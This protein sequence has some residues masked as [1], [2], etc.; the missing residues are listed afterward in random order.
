MDAKKSLVSDNG[1]PSDMAEDGKF[2]VSGAPTAVVGVGVG[3][4]SAQS[5]ERMFAAVRPDLNAAFVVAVRQD[6]GLQIQ[7]VVEILTRATQA[8]VQ[9]AVDGDPLTPNRIH[10]GGCDDMITV[11]HGEVRVRPASEPVGHRG[12]ID[13][14]LISLAEHAQEQAVAVILTGLGSDGAAGVT[15]TKKFGGLSIVEADV[16]PETGAGVSG[17]AAVA[18]L[19]L[20]VEE[21]GQQIALY[22]ANLADVEAIGF[23]EEGPDDLEAQVGQIT[24][25]LRNVTSHD[26]HGY[27]RGTFVRRVHR[28][29]QVLQIDSISDYIATLRADTQEVQNLFQD[30]LIGVTQFFRDPAEF[31]ALERELPRLFA[32]KGPED[33]FRVWVLGCATGEEAYSLAI[34]LREHLSTLNR[35]PEVQI[36]ATDLD[37]RSLGLARAGRYSASIADH[38]RPDR[39]ERWFVREGDTYCVAKELR[40]MCVFSPHNIVKDAPFSRLDILSCRNLLIY[41]SIELQNRVIPI[42]HFA[43]KSGGVLF[44]GASENVT[45]HGKLFAPV[46]RKNRLFRRLETA[47]RVVPDFPLTPRVRGS[48]PLDLGP[49][50]VLARVTAS[51]GRQAEAIVE[52]Y[53]PA[54]VIVD[55][56]G[57]VVHFSGHTGRYIE[58]SAGAPTMSLQ[59]LVHRDL[60][61]DIRAALSRAAA[62]GGRVEMPR[63]LLRQDDRS[64]GVN[65]IVEP[66]A[67][68][69]VNLLVVVFQDLGQM[70]NDSWLEGDRPSADEHVQR[71][72]AELRVTRDR[73]QAT[74]EEQESTNEELKSSNEE[75]QSINEEMQSTNE[76]L[77]TSK[78]ELQSVNE[79]LQTVN[80]ELGHRVSEL[81]RANSDLK[82]LLESTQIATIFLDSEQRVRNFTPATAEIF[83]LLEADV[84]R[85]LYH[86][87]SRVAYPELQDDIR[88]VL[89][90][91]TPIERHVTDAKA[92]RHFG[93]RVLPY[94]SLDNYISG[95][96][97]T[98]TDLTAVYKAQEALQESEDRRAFVLSLSDALRPLTDSAQIERV[99]AERVGERLGVDRA[100]YATIVDER[101]A[102]VTADYSRYGEPIAATIAAKLFSNSTLARLRSGEPLAVDDVACA[103]ELS[104]HSRETLRALNVG[105][106]IAVALIKNDQWLAAFCVQN[107]KP[108][109]WAQHEVELIGEVPERTWAAIDRA[110]AEAALKASEMRFRAFV[111]TSSDAVY[112]MSPDWSEM[113]RLDGGDFIPDTESPSKNWM[114]TYITPAERAP[115][116]AATGEA[117]AEKKMFILEHRALRVDGTYGWVLSRAI[118]ILDDDGE[119]LEWMGAATD[120]NARREGEAAL[121]ESE[122]R[123]QVLIEGVP[124]L[125][126][127]AV[128]GGNWTWASPRWS[129]YTGQT[130]PASLGLGWLEALHPDDRN[131]VVKLWDAAVEQ[132]EFTAEYRVREAKS[133]RYHWFQARATPVRDDA[134][135]LIEWLGASTDVDDLRQLQE[136]QRILVAELQ[137][138]V[139]NMLTVI[140][141]VFA[142]TV[143]TGGDAEA[144]AAHFK[145]RLDAL[146]R[147]QVIV[148]QNVDGTADLETLI[149]DELLSVAVS[150]GPNLE[151]EGP[152][153]LLPAKAIESIGLA[154]HELTTNSLK[155]GA[156]K[157][158]NA[159]LNIRWNIQDGAGGPRLSFTW[160][161]QGVPA[162]PVKPAREGFG[163]ELIEEA[164]P[165]RLGAQTKLEF[166]GGGVRCS[167]TLP[168]AGGANENTREI[169]H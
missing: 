63:L 120:I 134:G 8:P 51:A 87:V 113:L 79:E 147:T 127:R 24:T 16:G 92:G 122:R 54:Y 5:L 150:D 45:R 99:A 18:D 102:V 114:E 131:H 39:L 96:V 91:L 41:L 161:E 36:F 53:A 21:I 23:D 34:L 1:S 141:S 162:V 151:I 13:T 154:I 107:F 93:A 168:I 76:E 124:Q 7:T 20:P 3:L 9:I 132:G 43:L 123:Q 48:V 2:E 81:G 27:K 97:V 158:P 61:L 125:V 89:K 28:R 46:D 138:R 37:A 139:R 128:D 101:E 77:E 156:L 118:P 10:V 167:I 73:L 169:K 38:I 60:R 98:F 56:Q 69:D 90:T 40:E 52:R 47:T 30:M 136:R 62:E 17:P 49:P 12:V 55:A 70:A 165:Y 14:L 111:T 82:N 4:R 126:W 32:G 67:A 142:R 64:F 86:V 31:E 11:E 116:S 85:P 71:L 59:N 25:A 144:T 166:L 117:I 145:G 66:V 121:R 68:G 146:A 75:Y 22:A 148:T 58:P 112:R 115:V 94:R 84:G 105:A 57:D 42:F 88:R 143:E 78:E 74:I 164:L 109:R 83:H 103:P 157:T 29:M 26:F 119:I 160:T 159:K 149:R 72:E 108:R 152:S 104:D 95:A 163:R 153:V 140:R 65:L 135:T 106:F 44:L 133:G 80:G 100:L 50:P 110:N 35:P 19:S 129:E 155:Y 15:A 6:E 33:H 137:H 130:E